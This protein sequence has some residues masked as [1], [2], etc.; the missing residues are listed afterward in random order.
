MILFT[1]FIVIVLIDLLNVD[2][3]ARF[4]LNL[5]INCI[6]TVC[7]VLKVRVCCLVIFNLINKKWNS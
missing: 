4:V 1:E 2:Q 6:Y 5:I 3:K 7:E